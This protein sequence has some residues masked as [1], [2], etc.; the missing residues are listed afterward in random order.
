MN[1]AAYNK[2]Q[3]E[4]LYSQHIR[5]TNDCTVRALATSTGMNYC[6]AY[7]TLKAAGRKENGG[8]GWFKFE[9]VL[10]AAGLRK[11]QGHWKSFFKLQTVASFLETCD[12]DAT[13]VLRTSGHTFTVKH[14]TVQES[15]KVDNSA[16]FVLCVWK[17]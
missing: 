13:Y 1:K 2:Q 17:L 14:A 10:K 15:M 12:K 7:E 9:S 16:D 3:N 11:V 8:L 4:K 5:E 6:D